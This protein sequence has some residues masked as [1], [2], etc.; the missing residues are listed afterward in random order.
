[1]VSIAI[2][3]RGKGSLTLPMEYRRK[4][5]LN[6]GDVFTLIDLGDGSFMLTPQVSRLASLGDRIAD[7]LIEQ[8]VPV[9]E[10]LQALDEERKRYY[11][12]HYV[13]E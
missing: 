9:E 5:G 6:E 2:Q 12:E 1:M 11:Q 8:D 10:V 7:L 3:I 4:Y 13:K